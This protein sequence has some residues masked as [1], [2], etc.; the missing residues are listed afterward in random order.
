MCWIYGSDQQRFKSLVTTK[1]L[2]RAR[3]V[4]CGDESKQVTTSW[5]TLLAPHALAPAPPATPP[6]PAPPAPTR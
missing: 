6:A 5:G 3:A 4:R 2:P 1:L